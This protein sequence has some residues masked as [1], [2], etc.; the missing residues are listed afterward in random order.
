MAQAD[1]SRQALMSSFYGPCFSSFEHVPQE[2]RMLYSYDSKLHVYYIYIYIYMCNIYTHVSMRI[3]IVLVYLATSL[4]GTR[5]AFLYTHSSQVLSCNATVVL[6]SAWSFG[7]GLFRLRAVGSS[8]L[9]LRVWG[10]KAKQ[11][12]DC[13]ASFESLPYTLSMLC[14]VQRAAKTQLLSP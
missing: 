11:L 12:P 9:G 5:E 2:A 1:T 7:G 6:S 8:L 3:C 14:V 10:R 13:L 4:L